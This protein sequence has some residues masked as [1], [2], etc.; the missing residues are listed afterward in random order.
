M[1]GFGL[2]IFACFLFSVL[3]ALLKVAAEHVSLGQVIFYRFIIALVVLRIARAMGWFEFK[4]VNK[5][6]LVIRGVFGATTGL[7]FYAAVYCGS[8]SHAVLLNSINPV[9][10]AIFSGLVI[11]ERVRNR[12]I[13]PLIASMVGLFFVV[14]PSGGVPPIGDVFALI[15]GVGVCMDILAVRVLRRTDTVMCIIYYH[16]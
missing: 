13:L 5:R 14:Q 7:V 4:P 3:T 6:W 15:S 10:V 1:L 8:I 11:G 12:V 16:C 2:I 9:L